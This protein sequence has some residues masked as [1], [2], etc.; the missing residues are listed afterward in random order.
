MHKKRDKYLI[1]AVISNLLF[2]LMKQIIFFYVYRINFHFES[3][4]YVFPHRGSMQPI[5]GFI[6]HFHYNK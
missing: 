6:K 3:M 5:T 1:E 4:K 2:I